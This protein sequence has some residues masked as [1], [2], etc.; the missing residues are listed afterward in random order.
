LSVTPSRIA[1]FPRPTLRRTQ[2]SRANRPVEGAKV[3]IYAVDP[4]TGE[5]KGSALLTKTTGVDGV[6]GRSKPTARPPS[7]SSW[8]QPGAPITHIHRSPL[9]RSLA[10]L[11]LRP[12]TATPDPDAGA[13]IL[14]TRPRGYFGL[15][16]DLVLLDGK[17][18]SDIPAGVP[19]VW[20]TMLK[21]PTPKSRPV[22]AEFN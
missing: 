19:G 11:E 22:V 21:L 18:P 7:S 16:R 6:W 8:R 12:S 14:M 1:I 5:R 3:E 4:E 9:P 13:E 20:N 15:P 2:P 17:R 10:E